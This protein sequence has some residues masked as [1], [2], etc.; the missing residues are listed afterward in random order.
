MKELILRYHFENVKST[1][2]I[3]DTI[4]PIVNDT[5]DKE[6]S[7]FVSQPFEGLLIL[8]REDNNKTKAIF[9]FDYV[10][11]PSPLEMSMQIM[12][13]ILSISNGELNI[14]KDVTIGIDLVKR[15]SIEAKYYS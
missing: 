8:S 6:I 9:K 10:D 4:V 7:Y 2:Q 5:F 1:N 15:E 13:I 12:R 11:Y 3:I 14:P